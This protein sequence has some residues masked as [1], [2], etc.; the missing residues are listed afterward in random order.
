MSAQ[1]SLDEALAHR[2]AVLAALELDDDGWDR[3]V[4]DQA[5][6][7]V[8]ARGLPFTANSVRDLLPQVRRPLI[9]ARFNAAHKRGLIRQTGRFVPSTDKGTHGHRIAEWVRA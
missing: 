2:D 5:I 4:I 8:A 9:G 1:L 6:E 7:A 3:K